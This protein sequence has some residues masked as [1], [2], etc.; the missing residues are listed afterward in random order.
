MPGA[1]KSRSKLSINSWRASGRRVSRSASSWVK[2]KT[3]EVYRCAN[4]SESIS[5]AVVS[6]SPRNT[7]GGFS[8]SS[9]V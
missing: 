6:G 8:R 2:L 5:S 3:P 4:P 9:P 1:R 7:S